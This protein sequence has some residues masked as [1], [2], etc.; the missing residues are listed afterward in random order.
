MKVLH[1]SDWHL[2]RTIYGRRCTGE[3]QQ[4]LDWLV[5][6][7]ERLQVDCLLIA[8][9][10]F[11][12]ATPSNTS[13]GQY[14]S[15][16]HNISQTCCRHV[17]VIGGNHDS[18][19][20]LNAPRQLLQHLNVFIVGSSTGDAG[21]EVIALRDQDNQPEA[22]ICAVPFL[23]DRDVRQAE[24]YESIE[25][26]A[27]KLI[28][29]I[30]DHYH[31]VVDIALELRRE[32]KTNIPIIAMGHLFTAGGRVA[33]DGEVR[34]LYIGTLAHVHSSSF[35]E[36]IDYLA[37]GHL[38]IAQ[39]VNSCPTMRYSGSPLQLSFGKEAPEKSVTVIEFDDSPVVSKVT[40]PPFLR[41]ETIGGTHHEI[42]TTLDHL[43]NSECDTNILLEIHFTGEDIGALRQEVT[44]KLQNS[45]V[46]LV[47]LINQGVSQQA[48]HWREH[49][50]S[51]GN[52]D[53]ETVFRRCLDAHN[54]DQDE[55]KELEY[56]FAKTLE[57]LREETEEEENQ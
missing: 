41:L 7:I 54:I 23:R 16:L 28:Q 17:V 45:R 9:D 42:M 26:K 32:I 40:V 4:F 53:E 18:P 30:R 24:N 21:D 51:L 48:L 19:S 27:R 20:L 22:I 50:E 33:E 10:V 36:G 34:D 5:G 52:L 46:E 6:E 43:S 3:F 29:G 38:H 13:Q 56:C 14:Y 12:S 15:F 1:T 44:E 25:D 47:R 37:L 31:K 39:K 55:R 8:G 49:A 57:L 2:G 11:D 35:P